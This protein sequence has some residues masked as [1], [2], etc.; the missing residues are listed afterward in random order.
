MTPYVGNQAPEDQFD[1]AVKR[2]DMDFNV[3]T[4][5]GPLVQWLING[6]DIRVDWSK[7]SLQYVQEN[8]YEFEKKMNV[9]EINQVNTW[10]FWVI[11]TVQGDPVNIPHPIHLHGHDFYVLGFGPGVWD[12]SKAG[13]KFTN[14]PRRDTATLP[15]GGYLILGFPA[16]NPGVWLMVSASILLACAYLTLINFVALSHRLVGNLQSAVI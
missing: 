8:D 11:Q 10:T 14:P 5:N 13:L 15:A 7:P 9:F 2:F 6:S 16:D 4:V 12:G 1:S 3:S